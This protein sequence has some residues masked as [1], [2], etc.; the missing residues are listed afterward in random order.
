MSTIGEKAAYVAAQAQTRR[1]TCHWPGCTTQVP[2]VMWGCARH[3]YALPSSLRNKI[4]IAFQ[5]GQEVHGTPSTAYVAVA[6]EVQ[7]WI[8]AHHPVG[9]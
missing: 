1:H 5:P 8:I 9:K 2:P 7:D 4:W 3:W 6:R